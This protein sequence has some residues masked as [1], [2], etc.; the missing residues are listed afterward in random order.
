[1]LKKIIILLS[2]IGILFSCSSPTPP[3][4][5]AQITSS[6]LPKYAQ[7]F[8]I[9]YYEDYKQ[10]TVL[11]PWNNKQMNFEYY[12]LKDSS[13]I[14][15]SRL[16]NSF[17]LNHNPK[18][19]AVLSSPIVGMLNR[20]N[21]TGTIQGVTDPNLIYDS[22]ILSRIRKG[23][24]QNIGKSI[25]LNMEKLMM[26]N[27]DIIIGSGWEQLSADY[28]KMVKLKMIPVLMYD[29]QE[30]HPLGKAEW[31]VFLAAFFNEE[32]KAKSLFQAVDD[33]YNFIKNSVETKNKPQVFNGSEYQGIWYSAGGKS[34]ISQLYKDAGAQYLMEQDSTS[35]SIQL[36]FEIL[37]D[38]AAPTPI[39]M[40]TGSNSPMALDFFKTPKYKVFNAVRN[41]RV[42]SYQQRINSKGANDYWE[43]GGLRPDL[44]LKDLVEIFHHSEGDSMD[45]YYFNKVDY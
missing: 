36:D 24:I 9:D 42:Y 14:P 6:Y 32:E 25:Q 34:Y 28:K 29:W 8:R 44:V 19:T 11:N 33:N 27:P 3:D 45:L 17:L 16:A 10:I 15:Q 40:Y 5:H 23:E 13:K 38:K 7:F 37:M 18:S 12:I 1:M 31:M 4:N 43:T 30:V 2:F 35:G 41:H 22:V 39:W 21:L 20:L 26:I